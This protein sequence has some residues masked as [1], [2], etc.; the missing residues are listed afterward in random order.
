MKEKL[1]VEV[2]KKAQEQK[3]AHA[4][5]AA[6][7]G[8]QPVRAPTPAGGASAQ[9]EKMRVMAEIQSKINAKLAALQGRLPP[10]AL[11]TP[12]ATS[13]P[14]ASSGGPGPRPL[15][16][17]AE[18]REIDDQGRVISSGRAPVVAT[19]A[20]NK[21]V[22]REELFK[23][24]SPVVETDPSKNPYFDPRMRAPKV[25]RPRRAFNFVEAGTYVRKAQRMRTKLAK[26]LLE[27]S[28]GA[29]D[30]GAGSDMPR[31]K[32]LMPLRKEAEEI[33]HNEDE[34]V[35]DVEWWDAPLLLH[36]ERYGNESTSADE[37]QKKKKKA[38]GE[39]KDDMAVADE[40]G[41]GKER[42]VDGDDEAAVSSNINERRITHLV[43]HPVALAPPTE[44]PP[45]GPMPLKL[46][47][48]E[49]KKMRR[50]ARAEKQR[51]QQERVLLG[52]DPAPKNRMKI[53]NMMKVLT[54]EAV[55]DPTQIEK[56]VR[57]EM[58][59]RAKAHDARNQERKLTPEQ[60][61]LKKLKK[62]KEDTSL[63]THVALFRVTNL[64]DERHKYKVDVNAQQNFLTGCAVLYRGCCLVLVEGGPKAI[65]RYKKLMMRR[66]DWND[67]TKPEEVEG[68]E[69]MEVEKEVEKAKVE[70][71]QNFCD[72]VWEGTVLKSA[73]KN[74]QVDVFPS[75]KDARKFLKQR[76]VPHYWDVCRAFKR[77]MAPRN[78]SVQ[79]IIA[80]GT[81]VAATNDS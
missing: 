76:G 47:K 45:P 33:I 32:S 30:E 42:V 53:S 12:T 3:E 22:Q 52:L 80:G 56:K 71:Q 81:G 73:F 49:Q 59:E 65:E 7:L 51:E 25:T 77:D 13:L 4:M 64:S 28:M 48:A 70:R 36:K 27:S 46:T 11:V 17:D 57:A 19:L 24:E 5:P 21:R 63:I 23:L 62:L 78:P 14:I 61:R 15:R 50:R 58:E 8:Q 54:T 29:A 67:Y 39:E 34:P 68:A 2:Q 43:E 1:K 20:I 38:E 6:P 60:A 41:K 74:F 79:A 9:D 18:G 26:E 35:P 55:Q 75:D 31:D 16:L 10:G 44:K 40:E 72:L 37:E 69:G 66:I